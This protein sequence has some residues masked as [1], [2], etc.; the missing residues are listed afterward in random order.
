[1]GD[2]EERQ[3]EARGNARLVEDIRE[4]ALD[5]LFTERELL[6]DVAV[7]AALDDAA[8][9]FKLARGEAVG[10]ALR[11]GSLL[12]ELV[13]RGDKIDDA[14]AA[15]PIIARVNGADGSLQMAGERIFEYDAARA[16]MQRLNDLLG[17]DGGSEKQNLG[18]GRP[19]HDGAH[20]LKARQAAAWRHREGGHRAGARASA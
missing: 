17:G 18:R 12:H 4:M 7:A 14:L 1:M 3:L 11:H 16:D 9:H 2:G 20:G 15:D 8:D 13:E 10:F 6:G 19:A 5:G